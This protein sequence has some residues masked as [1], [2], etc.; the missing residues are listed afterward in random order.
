MI[1]Q[2]RAIIWR[3]VSADVVLAA[4]LLGPLAAPL[5]RAWGL[6]VPHMVS[7]IIYTM[8]TFVCPQPARSLP[9]SDGQIMAVCMRCY[10]TV[11]GLL[12]TRLLFAADGGAAWIWLP[13]YG[14]RALP[15]FAALIFAYAAEF[16]GEVAGWWAFDNP[17]VTIAGL[18]SGI[19]LG[20]MFHPILQRRL[21]KT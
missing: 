4:L 7:G 10:G 14:L 15:L 8:G 3:G 6:P 12:A 9:F 20:L 13:R 1:R 2:A 16:A 11:L 5:L 21:P 17:I 19:G 18:I